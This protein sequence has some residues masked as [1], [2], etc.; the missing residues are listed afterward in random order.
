MSDFTFSEHG[1]DILIHRLM[2]WKEH[3]FYLDCG[4]YD[5]RKMSL[6][7][8]LRNFGWTGIN[9]DIDKEV[10]ERLKLD[11]PGQISVCA[12]IGKGE[13]VATLYKYKDPVLNTIDFDQHKHLQKIASSGELHTEFLK[14]ELVNTIDLASLIA[15]Y[16]VKNGSIDFLNLDIEGVE[17][18][19]LA[20]F[21]WDKQKPLVIAVEIHRLC[22][23]KSAENPVVNFL[24]DVGYV[25]QSYVFHTAIFIHSDFDTEL[26]HRV[27]FKAL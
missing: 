15:K 17:L 3:G 8:R 6:T 12:A 2:L 23:S 21:P 7:A 4:A 10:V 26:C 16:E 13:G 1:E 11:I 14:S 9:V 25:M 19:A 5:A 24:R 22:L 20:G 18:T 27:P